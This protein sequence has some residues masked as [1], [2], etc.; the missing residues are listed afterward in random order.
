MNDQK[1]PVCGRATTHSAA[2]S[3]GLRMTGAGEHSVRCEECG[4][5]CAETGFLAHGWRHVPAAAK[6]AIAAYLKK[7]KDKQDCLRDLTLDSWRYLAW[8]GKKMLA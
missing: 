7:T 2:T 4:Q 6:K 5:F 8:Q 1:C 3:S